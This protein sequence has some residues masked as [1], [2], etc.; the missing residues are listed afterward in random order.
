M[1]LNLTEAQ[2]GLFDD[3]V[4]Q[5]REHPSSP[6]R[7]AGLSGFPDLEGSRTGCAVDLAIAMQ[8]LGYACAQP[9]SALA[10]S[11]HIFGGVLPLSRWG[12]SAQRQTYLPR[13]V[14]GD[15]YAARTLASTL[16]AKPRDAGFLLSGAAGLSSAGIKP[17]FVLAFTRPPEPANSPVKLF[18]LPLTEVSGVSWEASPGPALARADRLRLD[19]AK[20]SA[21][22]VL[23]GEPD[24]LL[25]ELLPREQLALH[26]VRLG[27]MQRLLESALNAAGKHTRR[28]KLKGIPPHRYQM[29]GHKLADL[30]IR[31]D[32]TELLLRRAAWQLDRRGASSSDVALAGLAVE[33]SLLPAAFEVVKLQRDHA[34]DEERVWSDWL[35]A[36]VDYG[37]YLFDPVQMRGAVNES[38]KGGIA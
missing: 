22:M 1:E 24:V 18:V 14:S 7:R 34:L 23:G 19:N 37:R 26:A 13:L 12:S 36:A 31:F 11:C 29:L 10:L 3:I 33:N 5:L 16:E 25:A 8:A 15:W 27:L 9:R 20:V 38:L 4:R 6:D 21:S 30:K 35:T 2:R 28:L 32:A 17:D